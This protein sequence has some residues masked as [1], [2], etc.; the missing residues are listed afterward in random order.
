MQGRPLGLSRLTGVPSL[1]AEEGEELGGLP[2]DAPPY[3]C[4]LESLGPVKHLDWAAGRHGQDDGSAKLKLEPGK[5]DPFP[6]APAHGACLPYLGAQ[7]TVHSLRSSPSSHPPRPPPGA[8]ASRTSRALRDGHQGP[9]PPPTPG[10]FPQGGLD[11]RV[12]RPAVQ[13]LPV[14]GYPAEDKLR[15]LLMPPGAPSHPALSL[16]VPIKME[17]DSGSEDAAD[18][19]RMSPAQVWLGA[20]NPAKRQLVT[21]PT[22]MHL[23]T[24]PGARL[25]LYTPPPGPGQ[26]GAPPRPGRGLAPLHPTSCACLEPPPR[27]CMR[28]HQ[29]FNL[30]CNC[31]APGPAPAVKLE[32][33]D[34]PLWAAHGQGGPPGLFSKSAPAAGMPPRDTQCAFLP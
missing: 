29:P 7:G 31:R 14:G 20:G 33:L 5:A 19:Y 25:P 16:D 24:E 11:S 9:A 34:S 27:L 18:G 28:G 26:L 15:G 2:R 17:S 3:S 23:K 12:P 21:F 32:P 13:R 6:T 10:P 4:R 22:R 1:R 8:C 30:G